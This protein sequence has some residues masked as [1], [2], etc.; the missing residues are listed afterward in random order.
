MK[1]IKGSALPA[2]LFFLVTCQAKTPVIYFIYPHIGEMG[3]PVTI[4]GANFG[5]IR[6]ETSYVTIAGAQPTSMSYLDWRDS[7]ISFRTPEFGEAGLVYVHVK[8]KKSNGVL[9]A[10][11][12][13]LPLHVYDSEIGQGPRIVSVVPNTAMTGSLVSIS[14][15]GFGSSRG[16]SGVFFSWNAEIPASM[17]AEARVPEFT[18]VMES[19]YGYELWSEREIRV[20]VPDGVTGGNM[21]V[22]TARGVSPPFY[23][24]PGNKP[25]TKTYRDK[26]SYTINYTVNV[27]T[28]E[29]EIPNTLYLWVPRP[30]ASAAQR[31]IE[32]LSSSV[33]PFVE[34]YRGTSLFKL[35]DLA[36]NSEAQISLSWKIEVYSVESSVRYQSIRQ[37]ADSQPSGVYTQSTAQLPS[38]DPRIRNQAAL[39]LGRERNSYLKAQRIY[40]WMLKEF[41]Y[42][43]DQSDGSI[44]NALETKQADPYLAALLCCTLMR[45]AGI[46]SQPVAGVLISRDRQTMDHYWAEFWIDGFG[47]L[48][49]DPVMG[50]E[51]VPAQF[52]SH[53]DKANFYFGNTDS[54]RI[55]F[56]RGF[57]V[58]SPM[59]PRGRT[60]TR[61]RSYA[62]QNLWE[63]VVGGIES[64]SSLW[65]GIT[66]TG[67]YA[68]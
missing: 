32:L 40:E 39:I 62:L 36:A 24:D 19:E 52:G 30:A 6:D 12:A 27:K 53:P 48:P 50:A 7:E 54:Q 4:T 46:P 13:T 21:E 28:A 58:L 42:Q 61:S 33:E 35:D 67:M 5:K 20:R 3:E 11:Q 2:V 22:R 14:G 31:N 25:G 64:Y 17:P 10:N 15:T 8:G 45:S 23:F 41:I 37:D 68:Q 60:V 57:A 59:D 63:E 16:N 44:F 49:A 1:R 29:A 51:A 18:E 9:F 38:D 65:G 34:S 55:A 66:I 56:S 26:R 43:P 47:W